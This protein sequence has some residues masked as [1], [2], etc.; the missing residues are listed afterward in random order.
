[1]MRKCHRLSK[2]INEDEKIEEINSKEPIE[3]VQSSG[4]QTG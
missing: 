1:M 4:D 3:A 2:E